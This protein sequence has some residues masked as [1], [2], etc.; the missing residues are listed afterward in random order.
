MSCFSFLAKNKNIDEQQ[1]IEKPT[2]FNIAFGI[3]HLCNKLN[4]KDDIDAELV[5]LLKNSNAE[6]SNYA[7]IANIILKY[8]VYNKKCLANQENFIRVF[9]NFDALL[10]IRYFLAFCV[11]NNVHF[12]PFLK[13]YNCGLMASKTKYTKY[14]ED[15]IDDH[16][17]KVFKLMLQDKMLSTK[18]LFGLVRNGYFGDIMQK[19]EQSHG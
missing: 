5:N 15:K 13:Y 10:F 11:E 8:T 17:F 19:H 18:D 6:A 2:D 1:K 9:N 3:L 12:P 7:F 4:T 16:E 14:F